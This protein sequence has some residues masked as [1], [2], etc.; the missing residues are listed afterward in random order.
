MASDSIDFKLEGLDSLLAKLKDLPLDLKKKSGR[1]A[2]RKAANLVAA[3]VRQN[4]QTLD[5]PDTGRTIA[6]NVAVRWSS[7]H[8]KRTGDLA[9]RVGIMHGA[10]LPDN[11]NPD[12]GVNGPT[13]HW[14]LLE[15]G[16]SKMRAHPFFRIGLS[17]NIQAATS[18]FITEYE[19]AIDRALKRSRK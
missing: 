4:A 1:T 15:F 6:K 3:S 19:K 9:F 2:L 8:H 7:K 13:P 12:Q 18:A 5:D 11:G 16:T 17:Q 14:R 10:K